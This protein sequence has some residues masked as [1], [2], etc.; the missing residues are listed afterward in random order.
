MG[1]GPARIVGAGDASRRWPFAAPPSFPGP[2]PREIEICRRA[3]A[4]AST[5]RATPPRGKAAEHTVHG[6]GRTDRAP[7]PSIAATRG[8]SSWSGR[9]VRPQ[10]RMSCRHRGAGDGGRRGP[11]RAFPVAWTPSGSDRMGSHLDRRGENRRVQSVLLPRSAASR[12]V[13]P[14]AGGIPAPRLESAAPSSGIGSRSSTDAGFAT[15]ADVVDL[16]GDCVELVAVGEPI[17]GAR[18]PLLSRP[19]HGGAQGRSVRL[20]GREGHR[21]GSRP[22][23]PDVTE[24]S[25]VVPRGSKLDRLRRSIIE[26]SKQCRR[27]RLMVLEEPVEWP[28]LM[29][30]FADAVRF[31]AD[32][33]GRPRIGLADDRPRPRRRAGRR[34]RRRPDGERRPSWPSGRGWL[35]IRL[36]YNILRVETAGLAGCAALLARVPEEQ[37]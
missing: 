29:A 14:A 21:A 31:V 33:R 13:P 2:P 36:G 1:T 30:D 17:P 7:A 25:V 37:A 23:H 6:P 35:R 10:T 32:P 5:R 19:R 9:G 27:A 3:H 16:N 26:A 20:A 22:A 28:R 24:R 12:P 34:A 4:I 18:A 8:R 11:I 15:G